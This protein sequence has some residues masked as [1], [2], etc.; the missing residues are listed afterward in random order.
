M[1]G[2]R[3]SKPGVVEG[4]QGGGAQGSKEPSRNAKPGMVSVNGIELRQYLSVVA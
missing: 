3:R 2:I 1:R 4:D